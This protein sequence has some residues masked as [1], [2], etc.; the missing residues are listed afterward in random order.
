M[1]K[2]DLLAFDRELKK[3]EEDMEI[4][5]AKKQRSEEERKSHSNRSEAVSASIIDNFLN[6]RS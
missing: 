3:A 2:K 4:I 1:S 6:S 5:R